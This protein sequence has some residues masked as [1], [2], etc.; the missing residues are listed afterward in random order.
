M[1]HIKKR[2]ALVVPHN[3]RNRIPYPQSWIW[4]QARNFSHIGDSAMSSQN[5]I[6]FCS[7][8]CHKDR[9]RGITPRMTNQAPIPPK[10]SAKG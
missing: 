7:L 8:I 3:D 10:L 2:E 5:A 6:A 1:Y 9:G 4:I